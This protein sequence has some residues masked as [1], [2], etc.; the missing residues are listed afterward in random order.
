MVDSIDNLKFEVGQTV[1]FVSC[2]G[3]NYNI[4]RESVVAIVPP[5]CEVGK[6]VGDCRYH[7][8]R[9]DLVHESDLWGSF[10]EA[11]E[12][13]IGFLSGFIKHLT[14]EINRI[15]TLTEGE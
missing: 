15:N 4:V 10:D 8:T 1:Y 7:L 12:H 3:G 13:L 11:K 9:H 14:A 5:H 6:D 2:D